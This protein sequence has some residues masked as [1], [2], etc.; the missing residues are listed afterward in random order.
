MT[1][2]ANIAT[3]GDDNRIFRC[4]VPN[5]G[6]AYRR[7]EHLIRHLR[8][9]R[10]QKPFNC[11]TCRRAYSRQRHIAQQHSTAEG[12]KGPGRHRRRALSACDRCHARKTRCTGG[13]PCQPCLKSNIICQYS[14]A[15]RSGGDV[16][17]STIPSSI[18]IDE[19]ADDFMLEL[20]SRASLV[21]LD[22]LPFQFVSDGSP[23]VGGVLLA[24][25]YGNPYAPELTFFSK[26][27]E[28]E[29]VPSVVPL[30]SNDGLWNLHDSE[31]FSLDQE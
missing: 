23:G 25:E 21:N 14:R 2:S 8:S 29:R 9:H 28:P 26:P 24:A 1:S 3:N 17:Q 13:L 12:A 18:T 16:L 27:N 20:A 22:S 5:C 31:R 6:K 7:N 15:D 30:V 19:S 10:L 4:T 11:P